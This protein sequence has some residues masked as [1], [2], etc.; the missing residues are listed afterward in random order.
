MVVFLCVKCAV[1][2]DAFEANKVSQGF[3]ALARAQS[4]LKS[5]VTLGRLAL[6]SQVTAALALASWLL[7]HPLLLSKDITHTIFKGF[8]LK[9][10]DRRVL[11]GACSAVHIGS[12]G[13]TSL[14]GKC[15]EETRCSCS[16]T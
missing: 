3:E 10:L 14:A 9:I 6:L 8:K 1:A 16:A 11:R 4:F 15:G 12:T 13:P 2:K 5:K 7:L